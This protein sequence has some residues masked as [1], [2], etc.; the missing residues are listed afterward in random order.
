MSKFFVSPKQPNIYYEVRLRTTIEDDL[1]HL[2]ESIRSHRKKAEHIIIYCCSLNLCADLHA[3]FHAELWD[4]SYYPPGALQQDA[5]PHFRKTK[6]AMWAFQNHQKAI[7]TPNHCLIQDVSIQWNS[8]Y[9]TIEHPTEQRWPLTAVF[10]D[11][12]VT[13]Q[14]NRY[15]NPKTEQ[16]DLLCWVRWQQYYILFRW[17]QLTWVQSAMYQ[18]QQRCHGLLQS[19]EPSESNLPAVHASPSL[20]L[21]RSSA[22]CF[23]FR[24]CFI[25]R[26][27]HSSQV[28]GQVCLTDR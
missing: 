21:R 22:E 12:S 16:W 3:H 26:C 19:L 1:A 2:V 7:Q 28:V 20:S 4:D 27:H 18:R 5:L 15:L 17:L 6:T 13:K 9:F 10:S 25:G 11:S 14:S 24:C 23:C 8:T